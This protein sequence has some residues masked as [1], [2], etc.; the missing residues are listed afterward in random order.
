VSERLGARAG[1]AIRRDRP[2]AFDFEGRSVPAFEG[3]T[4]GSALAAAGVT[5][6]GRS[7]KYHRARGLYCMTGSCPNCLMQVDGIPNVRSCTEPVRDGM[8][9][10]RQ[11]AWPNVTFDVHGW[12]N[13]FSFMMPPG[14]YYKI[15]HRPRWAWRTVEPFIRSKA[16]LG[17]VPREEDHEPREVHNLHADVL[18]I[19]AGAAGL[20]AAGEAA[21]AGLST[22]VLEE[23]PELGGADPGA[24]AD[25][26]AEATRA[27][28]RIL[29][30][31]AAFGVFGG[32][33]VAAASDDRL[34]RI[35]G[36]HVV[37]A[38]GAVEQAAVFPNNDLPGVMLSSAVDLLLEPGEVERLQ[39]ECSVAVDLSVQLRQRVG[40]GVVGR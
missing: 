5:I 31:T 15:F 22:V 13:T 12:L 27:G 32:P 38:T 6:T 2:I 37:F 29:L 7:F 16:G 34:Y 14:F 33:L 24:V 40:A 20:A 36:R 1:E 10:H 30:G 23:R 17:K 26:E 18:V 11:N 35:R 28:A 3:D 9:V 4:I 25:L 39:D 19:G 8:R 21:S